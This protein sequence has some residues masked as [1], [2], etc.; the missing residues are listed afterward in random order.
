MRKSLI[1]LLRFISKQIRTAA[2]LIA[3]QY[4]MYLQWFHSSMLYAPPSQVEKQMSRTLKLLKPVT[5]MSSKR[6]PLK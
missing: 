3:S 5:K 2:C 6:L 4:A 1:L